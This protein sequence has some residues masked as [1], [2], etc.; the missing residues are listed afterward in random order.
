MELGAQKSFSLL[1]RKSKM[2]TLSWEMWNWEHL[3]LNVLF[4][5]FLCC[6]WT[7]P[8]VLLQIQRAFLICED[9]W[10]N[11]DSPVS[12]SKYNIDILLSN[13]KL[14]G[15]RSHYLSSFTGSR[16]KSQLSTLYLL[17][18]LPSHSCTNLSGIYWG[19]ALW[20]HHLRIICNCLWN[21][22]L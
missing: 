22:I 13:L 7:C 5:L 16:I 20:Q 17:D 8:S 15:G 3:Y 18:C 1:M 4:H 11:N 2:H 6:S 9:C 14:H 19:I 12:G 10:R 21:V